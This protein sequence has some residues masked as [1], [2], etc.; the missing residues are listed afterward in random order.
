MQITATLNNGLTV[1]VVAVNVNG[2]SIYITYVD[3]SSNLTAIRD[4]LGYY[5]TSGNIIGTSATI[6]S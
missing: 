6:I 5:G 1:N 4:Y 2:D 3:N